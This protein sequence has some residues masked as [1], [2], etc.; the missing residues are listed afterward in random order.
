MRFYWWAAEEEGPA[1][2]WA[3]VA[4]LNRKEMGQIRLY[5]NADT[6]AS[7]NCHYGVL[8]SEKNDVY[9]DGMPYFG[10]EHNHIGLAPGSLEAAKFFERW[11]DSQGLSH[12]RARVERTDT[13]ASLNVG[14]PI[15]GLETGDDF[16]KTVEEAAMFG[17]KAD[18]PYDS[19][20][21]DVSD[22]Y[23]S[24]KLRAL[25]TN[26]KAIAAAVAHWG[27]TWEGIPTA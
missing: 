12:T 22:T 4:G 25:L 5:L 24:L 18:E 14:I 11:F 20:Y 19:H 2:S 15:S 8:A 26:T 6:L 17:G 21:H 1:G 3:Y 27:T 13:D 10:E 16:F 7:P 9:I 23:D